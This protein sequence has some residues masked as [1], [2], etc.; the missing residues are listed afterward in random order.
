[1]EALKVFTSVFMPPVGVYLQKGV[2]KSL[3]INIPLTALGIIPG[4]IHAIWCLEEEK[5]TFS[6]DRWIAKI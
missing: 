5:F 1:M 3:W 4:I 2:G 6:L